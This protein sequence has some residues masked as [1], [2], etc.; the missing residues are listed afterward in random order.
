M[1]PPILAPWQT[2]RPLVIDHEFDLIPHFQTVPV[3][4]CSAV[5]RWMR[6]GASET[7]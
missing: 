1:I 3:D 7:K 4:L 5:R 6:A 2:N